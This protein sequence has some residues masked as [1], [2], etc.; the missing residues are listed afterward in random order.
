M[1]E[2]R[3]KQVEMRKDEEVAEGRSMSTRPVSTHR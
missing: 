1:R 2:E 3:K